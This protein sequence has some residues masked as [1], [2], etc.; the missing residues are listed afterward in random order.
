M[1]TVKTV[2]L[3][4]TLTGLFMLIG[5]YI[6]GQTGLIIA[7]VLAMLMNFGSF[8]FSDK[9][10]L[11]IY[12]AQE[13]SDRSMP[14]IY[15]MVKNLTVKAGMSMPKVYIIPS[16]APNAFATGRDEKHAVVAVTQGILRILNKE[17]LEGVLAHELAH[18]K[19]KDMLIG[20]IAATMAG[21]IVMIANMAQWAAIFGGLGNRNEDE[22][23]S[24][25][26]MIGLLVMA[27]LA[28]VAATVIQMAI[29]RS[30][31]YLADNKGAILS[32]KP[33]SLASALEKISHGVHQEALHASPSTSH[34]FIVNPLT[35]RSFLSLFS[36]HPPVAERI[37]RLRMMLPNQ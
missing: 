30:R 33:Q 8:W 22:E 21:A 29:S 14:E 23:N 2:F 36:T 1:N 26:G 6:G 12:H 28:P 3:L 34:M 5:G 15:T 27:V 7:F 16:D 20:S 25:G 32:G 24:A 10:I 19:N 37:N 9:I 35:G 4:G 11:R 17:E 31:E 13:L 18:I